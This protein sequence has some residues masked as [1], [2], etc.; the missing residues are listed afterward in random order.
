MHISLAFW[1][2]H[3]WWSYSRI[4]L[5]STLSLLGVEIYRNAT[6]GIIMVFL[7]QRSIRGRQKKRLED[8]VKE[9][10]GMDFTSSTRAAENRTRQKGIFASLSVVPRRPSKVMR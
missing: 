5:N 9:W 7:G 6:S 8:N 1:F 4:G 10:T 2:D 3:S